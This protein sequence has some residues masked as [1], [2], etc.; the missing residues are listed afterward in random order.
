MFYS[1]GTEDDESDPGAAPLRVRVA[2]TSKI[3]K[4]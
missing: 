3:K 1:K 2:A 4:K